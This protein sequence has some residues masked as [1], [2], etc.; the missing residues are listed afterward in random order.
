LSVGMAQF[1]VFKYQF[2]G[3]YGQETHAWPVLVLVLMC[4]LRFTRK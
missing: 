1:D 2:F 4:S 3:V